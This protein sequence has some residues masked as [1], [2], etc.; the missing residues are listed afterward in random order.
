[1]ADAL[2][3]PGVVSAQD[4]RLDDA[5]LIAVAGNTAVDVR[6]GVLPG[7]NFTSLVVGTTAT[8]PMTV[9]IRTNH[10]V[11]SRGA[12]NGP[13]RG[14]NE[15][16]RV[17][18]LTAAPGSNSRI[19]VVYVKMQDNTPGIPTPD[20]VAGEE[21]GVVTGTAAAVPTK[22]ALPVGALELATVTITTGATNTLGAGVTIANTV[23]Y[24]G[25]RGTP[26]PVRN[27]TER[28]AIISAGAGYPTLTVARLDANGVLEQYD[29]STWRRY[30]FNEDTGW[31]DTPGVGGA[32]S[33]GTGGSKYRVRNGFCSLRS[34]IAFL[35]NGNPINL[36][37]P[38]S[39]GTFTLPPIAR[40]TFAI[41]APAT[42]LYGGTGHGSVLETVF[43][44][45]GTV[46]VNGR[47]LQGGGFQ[48]YATYPVG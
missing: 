31:L 16:T 18:N 2:H 28:D 14:S 37:V 45:D 34:H 9:Q 21:Y 35:N 41:A 42:Y 26:I 48:I 27:A 13:Y 46:R 43:G 15:V 36:T 30:Q 39:Q 25:L 33:F 38:D 24:T 19:D 5:G 20:G 4:A 40:P 3:T 23:R 8:A 17:V 1:M 7:P 22:P 11:T 32:F 44:T 47:G 6:T 29:G 12:A 10:W